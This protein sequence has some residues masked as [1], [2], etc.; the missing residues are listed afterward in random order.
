MW[1][2]VTCRD[3]DKIDDLMQDINEQQDVA[4]EISDAISRP[5]GFGEEFDEV[6]VGDNNRDLCLSVTEILLYTL[7]LLY[8]CVSDRSRKS[9]REIVISLHVI[10]LAWWYTF[11]SK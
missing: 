9:A 4:Q 6:I 11:F 2:V 1:N 5:V 7:I 8:S 3:V 10:V